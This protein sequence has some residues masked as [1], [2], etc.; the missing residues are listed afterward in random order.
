MTRHEALRARDDAKQLGHDLRSR[1]RSVSRSGDDGPE[2]AARERIAELL[3]ALHELLVE[4]LDRDAR[5]P[6]GR[7]EQCGY[8]PDDIEDP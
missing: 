6:S 8:S 4:R 3:E 2:S 5:A 1:A 7:C